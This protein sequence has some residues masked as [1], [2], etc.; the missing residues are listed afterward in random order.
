MLE[1][2]PT[3][4]RD[5]TITGSGRTGGGISFRRHRGD[6]LLSLILLHSRFCSRKREATVCCILFRRFFKVNADAIN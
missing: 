3:G 4:Q 6:I 1:I 5:R 2:E